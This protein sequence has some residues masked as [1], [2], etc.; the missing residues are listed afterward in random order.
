MQHKAAQN[1]NVLKM[2]WAQEIIEISYDFFT[3]LNLQ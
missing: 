1:H 3:R 2:R